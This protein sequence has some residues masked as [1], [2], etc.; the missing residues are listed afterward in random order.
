MTDVTHVE[1]VPLIQRRLEGEEA[2]QVVDRAND[3]FQTPAPPGPDRRTDVMDA[4]HA[5]RLE[6]P[7]KVEIEIGSIDAD[8]NIRRIGQQAGAGCP[9]NSRN[10]VVVLER[11]DITKDRQFIHRRPDIKTAGR[12]LRPADAEKYRVGNPRPD[13]LDQVPRQLVTRRFASDHRHP[14]TTSCRQAHR[15]MPRCD[16]SRK[17]TS[18]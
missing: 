14:Q 7:L 6:F 4:V 1:A 10:A 16:W 3:F 8:K 15:M 12:H 5:A 18:G 2:E 17:S 11:I 13:R 9:S